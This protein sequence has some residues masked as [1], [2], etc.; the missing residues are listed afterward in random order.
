MEWWQ[1]SKKLEE[2][3]DNLENLEDAY[4][5]DLH[6]PFKK[7]MD[8]VINEDDWIYRTKY[9]FTSLAQDIEEIV[10]TLEEK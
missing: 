3:E 1:E 6:G 10:K 8:S 2:F 9:Y 7:T 5:I 4:S